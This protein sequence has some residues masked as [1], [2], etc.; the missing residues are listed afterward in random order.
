MSRK[1]IPAH[2]GFGSPGFDRLW[3]PRGTL[4]AVC[5]PARVALAGSIRT[6]RR[7]KRTYRW[8]C[9]MRCQRL[10][11]QSAERID[12][13]DLTEE[14]RRRCPPSC[15]HSPVMDEIGWDRPSAD[16]TERQCTL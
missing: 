2:S 11:A 1:S 8:F 16:L 12:M 3:H 6:G 5:R 4:C 9:S 15:A 10:H 7:G 13:V 14:E